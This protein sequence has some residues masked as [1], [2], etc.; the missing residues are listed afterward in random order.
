MQSHYRLQAILLLLCIALTSGR[1]QEV[2]YSWQSPNGTVQETGGTLEHFN[3]NG[4]DKRNIKC[5]AFYTFVL[6]GERAYI[7]APYNVDECS[8]MKITLADGNTFSAGD[9]IEVT[10]MRNNVAD[11]PAS[12]CFLFHTTGMVYGEDEPQEIDVPI[13]DTNTWNNLGQGTDSTFGGTTEANTKNANATTEAGA[14]TAAYAAPMAA[15]FEPSTHTFTMPKEAAG[16][17]YVRLTRNETGNM[18]YVVRFIVRHNEASAITT[19]TATSATTRTKKII[20]NG[21]L[22]IERNGHTYD[23]CGTELHS[24]K[25]TEKIPH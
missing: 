9:E 14:T 18:L 22:L 20:K 25:H 4:C 1:A 16:A 11:R 10:A 7:N 6:N 21:R 15:P 23:I 17:R 12:I 5:G 24:R 8:Y 19:P 3:Q 2:L 13:I